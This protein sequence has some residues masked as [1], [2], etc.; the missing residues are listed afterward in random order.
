MMLIAEAFSTLLRVW[1]QDKLVALPLTFI[2]DALLVTL[3]QVVS[4]LLVSQNADGS[5]GPEYSGEVTAYAILALWKA[6]IVPGARGL[7][8]QIHRALRNGRE[9]LRNA[10]TGTGPAAHLWIEKVTYRSVA[11]QEAYMLAAVKVSSPEE[12]LPTLSNRGL[13]LSPIET[14]NVHQLGLDCFGTP[15]FEPT[16][17]WKLQAAYMESRLFRP[18]LQRLIDEVVPGKFEDD[19]ALEIIPFIW[20][21]CNYAAPRP[22]S[23]TQLRQKIGGHLIQSLLEQSRYQAALKLELPDIQAQTME[24]LIRAKERGLLTPVVRSTVNLA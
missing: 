4:R 18:Y 20:T 9:F 13:S 7:A 10:S 6:S 22:C 3:Y 1:D 12:S 17:A 11:L 16:E 19:P 21:A 15:L 23:T 24:A 5:W 8:E 14:A 2:T